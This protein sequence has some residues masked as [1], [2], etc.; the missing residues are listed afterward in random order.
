MLAGHSVGLAHAA[1]TDDPM[2]A[3]AGWLAGKIDAR[4]FIPA[5]SGPDRNATA[6]AVLALGAARVGGE[7]FDRAVAALAA[8]V[9]AYVRD[10][11]G[12]DRPAALG[13][14]IQVA[15]VAGRDPRAFGGVDL[16]ARLLATKRTSGTDA[17]L[18][19]S[20]DPAFDGAYRQ[21]FALLGL[22]A[23]GLA[24]ADAVRWLVRQQC[25]DGGWQAYRADTA[26]PCAP[27]NTSTFTGEDTNS[28]AV[29]AQALA[30]LGE[31]PATSPLDFLDGTQN[32]DGGFGFL[33]GTSTDANSTA[34]VIQAI[35][36]LGEDPAAGRW[37][38]ADGDI[39]RAALLRLQLG[40]ATPAA[41][42]GAF[43]Y[44]PESDGSLSPNV[45]ATV[46]V[47]PALAGMPYPIRPAA[48]SRETPTLRCTAAASPTTAPA[49]SPTRAA[50]APST[51]PPPSQGAAPGP[52]VGTN[53]PAVDAGVVDAGGQPILPVNGGVGS[54]PWD[55]TGLVVFGLGLIGYGMLALGSARWLGRVR[56]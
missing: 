6:L 10:S 34:L 14:L 7:S 55:T 45:L 15:T 30:A 24:D 2:L 9:D 19:G 53:G 27:T 12:A 32:A 40:C 23:A 35:L 31:R 33:D 39:P 44:Q 41:D 47:V 37:A 50:P 3:G 52:T 1:P 54:A 4:G 42:R 25:P 56:A 26:A 38:D 11:T 48:I 36:A 21:S 43:A 51:A 17:G 20:Q 8:N 28:T 16:V 18:F 22:D 49:P 46:Q 5:Q 29:A 13:T